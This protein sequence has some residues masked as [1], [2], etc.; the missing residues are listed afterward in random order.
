[1]VNNV[2]GSNRCYE[3]CM[4]KRNRTRKKSG[5]MKSV[6]EPQMKQ[7]IETNRKSIQD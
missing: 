3:L 5:F 7:K 2:L 6:E 4:G 1:M